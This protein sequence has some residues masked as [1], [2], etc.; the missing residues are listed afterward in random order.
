MS[1]MESDQNGR[2]T[3][4]QLSFKVEWSGG[5]QRT[6]GI[7]P[8]KVLFVFIFVLMSQASTHGGKVSVCWVH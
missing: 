3:R 2:R 8:T 7:Y 5:D 4:E 6:G 1:G